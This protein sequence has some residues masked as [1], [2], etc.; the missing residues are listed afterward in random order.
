MRLTAYQSSH[1]TALR[2]AQYRQA[3]DPPVV[4]SIT[5]ITDRARERDWVPKSKCQ[6]LELHA[7]NISPREQFTSHEAYDTSAG[8][9][10]PFHLCNPGRL[11]PTTWT[12]CVIFGIYVQVYKNSQPR[13]KKTILMSLWKIRRLYKKDFLSALKSY[14]SKSLHSSILHYFCGYLLYLFI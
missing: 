10:M 4:P 1:S 6:T 12:F 3:S 9:D 5:F 7:C 13:S 11:D 14:N 2:C 8:Q